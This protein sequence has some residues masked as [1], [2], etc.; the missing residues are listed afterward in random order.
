MERELF[1]KSRHLEISVDVTEISRQLL[2]GS[3]K[4]RDQVIDML[5]PH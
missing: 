2:E 1:Q 4:I 3:V 5:D